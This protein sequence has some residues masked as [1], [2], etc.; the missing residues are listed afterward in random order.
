MQNFDKTGLTS[1][2]LKALRDYSRLDNGCLSVSL[3]V[4]A[5]GDDS[6]K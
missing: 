3:F 2:V 5:V 6:Q 4:Y 1:L